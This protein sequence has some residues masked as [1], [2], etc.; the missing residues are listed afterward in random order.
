MFFEGE[1]TEEEKTRKP[2]TDRE[3]MDI[4]LGGWRDING[5]GGNPVPFDEASRNKVLGI[6][7]ALRAIIDKWIE[8]LDTEGEE[9]NSQVP[10]NTGQPAVSE[11]PSTPPTPSPQPQPS[12]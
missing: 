6:K 7:G 4:I 2:R 5:P 1:L 3:I 11:Q 9:K 12:V 8:S 10:P